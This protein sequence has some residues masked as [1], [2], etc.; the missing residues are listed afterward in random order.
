MFTKAVRAW[1]HLVKKKLRSIPVKKI[2]KNL[3]AFYLDTGSTGYMHV[4][5]W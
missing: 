4:K 1:E 5:F 2:T 3:R